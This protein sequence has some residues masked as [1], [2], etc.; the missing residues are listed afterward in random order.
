MMLFNS[1]HET[2]QPIVEESFYESLL[3]Q[4][5]KELP[6]DRFKKLG[7]DIIYG[8]M[9]KISVLNVRQL[10]TEYRSKM[11][12]TMEC[13]EMKVKNVVENDH[14]GILVKINPDSFVCFFPQKQREAEYSSMTRCIA[15]ACTLHSDHVEIHNTDN[16]NNNDNSVPI[17][18]VKIHICISYGK[19]Y[20][21]ALHLQ[22]KIL[23]DYLGVVDDVLFKGNNL[24]FHSSD[25]NEQECEPL[26]KIVIICQ[27][28]AMVR[29]IIS[30]LRD[31]KCKKAIRLIQKTP[32]S[33]LP[34]AAS[35]KSNDLLL[36][37]AC[38]ME[39]KEHVV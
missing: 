18:D 30:Q 38:S 14:Q 39:R 25:N 7:I 19:V 1:N 22:K 27:N 35:T 31:V 33:S 36:E 26:D 4:A 8:T 13:L 23:H 11:L 16:D 20:R 9:M 34:S 21:K 28:N 29:K 15:A 3:T 37:N 24:H 10:W 5:I 12:E 6:I 32:S 2:Y 17:D